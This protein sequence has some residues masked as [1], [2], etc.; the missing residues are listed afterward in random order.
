MK[1]NPSLSPKKR[2]WQQMRAH[3][4]REDHLK[5]SNKK[6]SFCGDTEQEPITKRMTSEAYR[7]DDTQK[8][9]YAMIDATD[10]QNKRQQ[11]LDD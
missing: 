8:T 3:Q 4:R 9:F 2:P 10:S 6:R 1:K 11:R 5:E 7:E